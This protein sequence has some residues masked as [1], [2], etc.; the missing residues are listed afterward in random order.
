M[1]NDARAKTFTHFKAK[2]SFA[3]VGRNRAG[4]GRA[5]QGRAGQGRAGQGRAGQG[6]VLD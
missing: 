3:A 2:M 1:I 4:Q 6:R 5:G